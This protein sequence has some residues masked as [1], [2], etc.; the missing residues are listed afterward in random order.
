MTTS[1]KLLRRG[2]PA[3]GVIGALLAGTTAG[4]E[5]SSHR[6]APLITE[7]PVADLTDVYAFVSP[8]DASKVT[9]IANVIPFESPAGGPN[10]YKFGDDVL[11]Q[12]N[13]SNDGDP[14]AEIEYQFRFTTTYANPNTFLY[15]TGQVTKLDDADL[16][17][18][19]TYS[20][21]KVNKANGKSETLGKNLPVPPANVGPRSTPDYEANLGSKGVKNLGNG[22][23]VFAGP[24]TTR[25]SS[26]W[27]ASSTLADC[28][29]STPPT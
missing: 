8:D 14:E 6:E 29:R 25:S 3:L 22:S 12:L 10:F 28:G 9:L 17:L 19:Q 26:T 21:T 7:D 23:R 1:R 15:N 2:L 24:A 16:N 20:V 4:V 5:A 13:V 11:Y 18:R 27:A